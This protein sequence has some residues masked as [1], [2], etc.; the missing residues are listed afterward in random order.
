MKRLNKRSNKYKD[1]GRYVEDYTPLM[2]F[3]FLIISFV[4]VNIIF[5]VGSG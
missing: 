5:Y 3:S 4:L 1:A 2:L